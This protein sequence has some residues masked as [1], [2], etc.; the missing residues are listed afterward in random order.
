MSDIFILYVAFSYLFMFVALNKAHVMAGN[1]GSGWFRFTGLLLAPLIL[2]H[3][4]DFT[5]VKV[6]NSK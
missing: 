5:M 4:L 1:D 6:V 3:M 2:P